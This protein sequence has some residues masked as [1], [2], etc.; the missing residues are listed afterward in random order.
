MFFFTIS[1]SGSFALAWT[2]FWAAARTFAFGDE[3][4]NMAGETWP[5][6]GSE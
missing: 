5:F 1:H 4:E 3:F 6:D 2:A